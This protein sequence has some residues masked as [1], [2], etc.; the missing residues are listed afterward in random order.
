MRTSV[1]GTCER[2]FTLIEMLV[3]VAI[4]AIAASMVSLSV[5]SS[6]E[7]ALR[8]DAERLVDAFAV[9][10]SEARSDG[11]AI[12]WRADERGWSFERRGRS[13][14][15]SAQDDGPQT[16]DRFQ[17][18]TALRA[19]A[20]GAPPVSL[21]LAPDRPVVFGTEWVADPLV[22]ELV[23]QDDTVRI[24]RDAAGSYAIE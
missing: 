19:Q 18:D 24:E 22:L 5:A 16:P 4:I 21:R 14:R 9:A 17:Q 1:R 11:R 23:S 6:S 12:R 3:V 13:A 7:R 10:Q 15:L 20:W 2:G 8:A